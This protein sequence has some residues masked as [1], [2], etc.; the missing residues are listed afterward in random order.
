[1]GKKNGALSAI[2]NDIKKKFNKAISE[3]ADEVTFQID[4]AYETVIDKFYNDYTPK[5]YD[6]TY[7]TY[8]AARPLYDFMHIG[9][10]YWAG[11]QVDSANILSANPYKM[12]KNWVFD[13]T[14]YKGVH[15]I[16]AS[17]VRSW[18]RGRHR[19][20]EIRIKAPKQMRPTPK[21]LMDKEFKNIT[22][23][24]NMDKFLNEAISKVFS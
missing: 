18:N 24:K 21:A 14:F 10:S 16:T 1:M 12:P 23:K 8:E 11:I 9:D 17:E 15:G 7:S 3:M 13:R 19:T 5:W 6:R 4:S 20:E 2:E 22:S